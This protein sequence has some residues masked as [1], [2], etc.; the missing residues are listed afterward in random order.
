M[1]MLIIDAT[2]GIVCP[3]MT[4]D[5]ANVSRSPL[6]AQSAEQGSAGK[7]HVG[8]RGERHGVFGRKK[9]RYTV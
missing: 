8:R 9:N 1:L 2:F 3:Y 6:L 5:A 7:H 4:K